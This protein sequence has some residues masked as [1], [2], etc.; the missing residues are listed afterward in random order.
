MQ[1]TT[2]YTSDSYPSD[3]AKIILAAQPPYTPRQQ[4]L[5]QRDILGHRLEGEIAGG[6][7]IPDEEW[8]DFCETVT[9]APD[10]KL[11]ELW[12]DCAEW[13]LSRNDIPLVKNDPI[14]QAIEEEIRS[15]DTYFAADE[16]P[17]RNPTLIH[18]R[19]KRFDQNHNPN[20][21]FL[22]SVYHSIKSATGDLP[23]K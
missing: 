23:T 8:Y 17:V 1:E 18:Q 6:E 19:Y 13:I 11:D 22:P 14:A 4:I 15:A 20:Y 3:T 10:D 9:E 16:L 12:A 21:G 7:T 5:L 2:K